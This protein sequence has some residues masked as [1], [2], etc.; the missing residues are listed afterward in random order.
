MPEV[1]LP[2]DSQQRLI[3]TARQT[4]E[5]I[6]RGYPYREHNE[7][8]PH[9]G[10]IKYG[11]FVTL[12]NRHLLRGC[13]GTCAPS[14]GLSTIV[15]EMTE[16]AATRDHRVKPVGLDELSDIQIHISVI[17]PLDPA[18]GP[19]DLEI[20]KHG[21][22]IERHRRRG[23]LL[24]QVAVEHGWDTSAFLEQT[25]LKAK[26]PR[27]AWRWPGTKVSLFTALQIEEER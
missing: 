13:V 22:H 5:A 3:K 4:L 2:A 1:Y 26:L 8:D 25:C 11:A 20:G 17:S 10:L 9:L 12:W 19:L 23:V 27:N 16:A 7:G 18:D 21:L 6:T 24:P 15:I 14:S